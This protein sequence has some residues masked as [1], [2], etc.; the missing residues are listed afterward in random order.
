[1]R[2]W[3]L[4]EALGGCVKTVCCTWSQ[5]INERQ[6]RS[7]RDG[8]QVLKL[9]SIHIW[10]KPDAQPKTSPNRGFIQTS[11]LRKQ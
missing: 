4:T 2:G 6:L 8:T 10:N 5:G 11:G 9:P 1:M 7:E 3:Q